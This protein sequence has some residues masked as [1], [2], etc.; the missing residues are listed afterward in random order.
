MYEHQFLSQN[1][2]D[3]LSIAER[4][5]SSNKLFPFLNMQYAIILKCAFLIIK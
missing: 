1:F 3:L 5:L 4:L 2:M